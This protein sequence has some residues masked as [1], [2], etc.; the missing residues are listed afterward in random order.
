MVQKMKYLFIGI[1]YVLEW[2]FKVGLYFIWN[3]KYKSLKEINEEEI[4]N[5]PCGGCDY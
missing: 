1:F 5:F 3:F 2:T 4:F